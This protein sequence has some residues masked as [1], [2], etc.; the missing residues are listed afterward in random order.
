MYNTYYIH[1]ISYTPCV[2]YIPDP[3]GSLVPNRNLV[4]SLR[5]AWSHCKILKQCSNKICL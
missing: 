4:I 3:S 5:A 2:M 1:N